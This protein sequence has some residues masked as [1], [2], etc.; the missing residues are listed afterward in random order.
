MQS[1]DAAPG[2][3][4]LG[5]APAP[6]FTAKAL[7]KLILPLM[8]EQLLAMSVG[9]ADTVMLTRVGE[10]AVSGV[11]LVDVINNLVI[12]VLAALATGGAVVCS[13]YLGRRDAGNARLAA[14]QLL[15]T[16]TGV[17][18][19]L[20]AVLLLFRDALLPA[21]FGN[22]DAPV[23]KSARIYL[24]LTALSF[25]FL[26]VYNACAAM[27]RSMG[28]SRV[29][30]YASILMNALNIGGN[31]VLIYGCGWGT[32]GAG[33]ATLLSRAAAAVMMLLLIGNQG[34]PIWLNKLFPIRFNKKMIAAILRIG[35]PS[36][37]ENG[38]FH[39][40][41]LAVQALIASLG[42]AAIAANAIV[43]SISGVLNVPGMSIGLAMITVV[44][45]CAGTG[46]YRQ[47]SFYTK[48]LMLYAYVCMAAVNLPIVILAKPFV[49]LFSLS[50]EATRLAVLI[51]PS[52]GIMHSLAWPMSFTFPNA[53][54]AAGDARY[55]MLVSIVSMWTLRVGM[56]YVFVRLFSLSIDGVWYAMF[57]DWGL[58]IICFVIRYVN[59]KWKTKRVI[60]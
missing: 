18:L 11:A 43:S 30:L 58:R 5:G 26:A 4:P 19:V 50:P 2:E 25:P 17:A 48:R 1:I 36:G 57:C 40:G 38:L 10:A 7:R 42:T 60:T 14:R 23:M 6:L 55:T 46:D 9:M 16:A 52:I 28:N 47:A 31:A 3:K 49:A 45:Q 35:V 56:S 12:Q 32:A 59:G 39:F 8:L 27:F 51:L 54:R 20:A 37:V 41:K 33:T 13:Q 29:S 15:Y 44:G 53:L 21:I 24:L 34:N 22:L